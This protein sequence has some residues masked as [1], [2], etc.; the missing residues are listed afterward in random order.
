[1]S[2]SV[3]TSVG[4]DLVSSTEIP[5]WPRAASAPPLRDASRARTS[6][7]RRSGVV[8][9][10][11][12]R[13]NKGQHGPAAPR[14]LDRAARPGRRRRP[15]PRRTPPSVALDHVRAYLRPLFRRGTQ[16]TTLGTL[17]D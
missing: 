7:S 12:S 8:T 17:C 4:E 11:Y 6:S 13:R 1:R 3:T 15:R 9:V 10:V 5:R 16:H 14:G 2:I